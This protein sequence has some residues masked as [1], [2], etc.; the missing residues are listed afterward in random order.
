MAR[1]KYDV[2]IIGSGHAGGMAGY[3]LAK[4][5]LSC[6]MLNAG[7]VADLSRDRTSKPVYELPFRGFG[8]P[9]SVSDG[10]INEYV[11]NAFVDTVEVPYTHDEDKPY[12]WVRNRLVGGRS[13]FWSRQSFRL[14]DYEF[15]AKDH[16]DFGENWPISL[17]DLAP[18]YEQ[19]ETIFRVSGR[20]EGL[21]QFP[22][23]KFVTENNTPD[24]ESMQRFIGAAKKRGITVSKSRSSLGVNGLASSVNLL[25]PDAIA[26]GNLTIV[27]NAVVREVTVDK[28]TGLVDGAHFIERHSRRELH[29]SARVVVLAAGCL[30]STRLL[31]N[32]GI[33]NS[34]GVVGRYLFDQFYGSTVAAFV[35]EALNG[36]AKPG[37]MG[38]GGIVVPFRNVE[39]REK[40][41]I[42]RY[43]LTVRSGGTPEAH[44][45][46]TYGA[47]LQ[48]Q[49]AKYAGAGFS[50]GIMGEV[51]PRWEN[52]VRINKNVVDAWGIPVLH[53]EARYGDNERN[54]HRDAQNS[55]EE[56]CRAAGFEILA[57]DDTHR[58]PGQSVHELGTCRMGD[59]PKTSVLN[60][61]NQSH[62]IKNMFVV[63]GSSFVTGGW[64]NPT[65]TIS[66][67]SMRSSEYL[68]EQM[69]Q[70]IL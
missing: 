16:D 12:R 60:K 67:L 2:L 39:R 64:Q 32:S 33:A 43:V 44:L 58:V 37:L 13:I 55:M 27:P 28:N 14:S 38:G 51:L 23:A 41:F 62:D 34:S 46:P 21:P 49:L 15:K 68:A 42:R 20:P 57:R 19:V 7:P 8:R 53:I 3:V 70:R 45:F 30:E 10:V 17:A 18:Y 69:R 11:L 35:P 50:A 24:S 26:T 59:N 61:W 31:L 36:K 1:K 52:H 5:G 25:L 56:L 47:D 66:A 9:S 40:D 63:D 6:L 22:D 48:K 29:A 4:K 54:M 65:M